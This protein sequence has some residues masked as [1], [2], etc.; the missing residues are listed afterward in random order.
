MVILIII[1]I[2]AALLFGIFRL[3]SFV[4]SGLERATIEEAMAWQAE[5]Y[6][7]SFL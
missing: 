3:A 4:V 7:V 1:V 2:L 5:H 6:D